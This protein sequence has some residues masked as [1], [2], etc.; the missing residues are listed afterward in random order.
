MDVPPPA[1]A[2]DQHMDV[3]PPAGTEGVASCAAPAPGLAQRA[4]GRDAQAPPADHGPQQRDCN[5]AGAT[6]KRRVGERLSRRAYQRARTCLRCRSN[7]GIKAETAEAQYVF[8]CGHIM[9]Q[10]CYEGAAPRAMPSDCDRCGSCL[11]R[12][13][14]VTS[15]A[16]A[17]AGAGPRPEPEG[18][19]RCAHPVPCERVPAGLVKAPAQLALF[20]LDEETLR[21]ECGRC[22]AERMLRGYTA[23]AR[24]SGLARSEWAF[25]CLGTGAD[26]LHG[27]EEPTL[28]LGVGPHPHPHPHPPP[29]AAVDD[30]DDDEREPA[31]LPDEALREPGL[32]ALA[33]SKADE[34][35]AALGGLRAEQGWDPALL[36]QGLVFRESLIDALCG[37]AVGVAD[38]DD[39]G[40]GGDAAWGA[41]VAWG[42]A[43]DDAWGLHPELLLTHDELDGMAFLWAD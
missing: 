30:D 7:L 33:A 16:A 28:S 18:G 36:R 20:M 10:G 35:R 39:D 26:A 19:W 9:C 14:A 32:A 2:T 3:P 4:R 41:D 43:A 34:L 8:P 6:K 17:G 37:R 21:R 12:G 22:A 42:A 27:Q 29:P 11:W 24:A 15:G 13:A 31:V 1:E 38:T 25:A 23:E 5:G 40:G